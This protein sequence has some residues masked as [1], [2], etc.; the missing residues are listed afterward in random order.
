M[1]AMPASVPRPRPRVEPSLARVGALGGAPRSWDS[2][3]NRFRRCDA[4]DIVATVR[5]FTAVVLT[6]LPCALAGSCL[7]EIREP[8]RT[9]PSTGGAGGTVGP[10]TGG[11][12]GVGGEGVGGGSGGATGGG[13][14]CPDDMVHATDGADISFCID[15][16]EVTRAAYV[17]FLASVGGSVPVTD[18]PPA[19][20]FNT[21]L[22]HSPDGSCPDF[23]TASQLPVNC[24]DWCDAHAFC[25][26]ADKRLC[27]SL[28]GGPL[29]FDAMPVVSEWHF[30]C[31]GGL[32]TAYPYGDTAD[33]DACNIPDTSARAEVG[34]FPACEGG[35]PGLFDM[36]GNVAEYIDACESDAPDANCALRGG[37]TFGS[38]NFWRCD[39]TAS[40]TARNNP[41]ERE[42][43]FRCCRDAN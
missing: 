4:R 18:Q 17:Q 41:D 34:S 20:S 42:Y 33:P 37:H 6:L 24:V 21:E 39:N 8:V 9:S 7:V 11:T 26:W 28:A 32:M 14:P 40:S 15:R 19:C 23:T 43:G 22:T 25:A 12:G 36:Q 30:A 29:A 2:R 10:T 1:N 35:F 16:T 27:G 3:A 31:T 13:S 5:S 38:A